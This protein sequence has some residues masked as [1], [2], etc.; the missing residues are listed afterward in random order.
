MRASRSLF[1]CV[2]MIDCVLNPI[3][4]HWTNKIISELLDETNSIYL[5]LSVITAQVRP[6]MQSSA[7]GPRVF[8][9][10]AGFKLFIFYPF[11][12]N[13]FALTALGHGFAQYM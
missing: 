8:Y 13:V 10:G 11:F 12:K 6:V 5:Q 9:I 7:L 2:H 4:R 3:N 1:V